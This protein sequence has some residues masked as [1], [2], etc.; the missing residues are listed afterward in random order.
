MTIGIDSHQAHSVKHE[1]LNLRVVGSSPMMGEVWGFPS[2]SVRK[3]SICNAGDPGS[4]PGW[5]RASGEGNGDPL[6]YSCMENPW[7]EEP[8]K[9]QSMRSQIDMTE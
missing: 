3:E 6:W 1:A 4:I 8:G 2:G 5:G 9:L 7:T